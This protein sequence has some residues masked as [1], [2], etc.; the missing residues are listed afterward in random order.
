MDVLPV[1][2]E[3]EEAAAALALLL[4]LLGSVDEE[5]AA[6]ARFVPA[7]GRD[8]VPSTRVI[9]VVVVVLS[10]V[11]FSSRPSSFPELEAAATMDTAAEGFAN[12]VALE[13]LAWSDLD[14]VVAVVVVVAAAAVP[15]GTALV[16]E[17]E[18]APEDFLLDVL[19]GEVGTTDLAEVKEEGTTVVAPGVN[20]PAMGWWW[21]VEGWCGC[22][23]E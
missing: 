22:A 4:A 5:S 9:V 19:T 7:E 13:S 8:A 6:A 18:E 17:E 10:I 1:G 21:S 3:E 16:V 15:G 12:R 23:C 20:P 14:A 2:C 11:L